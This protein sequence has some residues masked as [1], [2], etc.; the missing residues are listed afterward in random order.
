MK[1]NEHPYIQFYGK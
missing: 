1:E